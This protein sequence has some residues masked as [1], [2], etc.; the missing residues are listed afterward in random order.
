[1]GRR[2]LTVRIT[3]LE[4][5]YNSTDWEIRDEVTKIEAFVGACRTRIVWSIP[6]LTGKSASLHLGKRAVLRGAVV[7]S[8]DHGRTI[9]NPHELEQRSCARSRDWARLGEISE[10]CA[11]HRCWLEWRIGYM[12][13]HLYGWASGMASSGNS[14]ADVSRRSYPGR[15]CAT[16]WTPVCRANIQ[17]LLVLHQLERRWRARV[18]RIFSR[19]LGGSGR[20]EYEPPRLVCPWR[21]GR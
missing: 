5:E 13:T 17:L 19:R 8:E 4:A 21:S 14:R 9:R 11:R 3:R 1:M 7:G 10:Y 12:P 15:S 18:G 16:G 20:K 6:L 2:R